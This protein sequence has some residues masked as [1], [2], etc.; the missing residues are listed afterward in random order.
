[1]SY[2]IPETLLQWPW[3]RQQNVHDAEVGPESTLWIQ[4]FNA[5][6]AKSQRAFDLCDFNE[7]RSSC[8]M[9]HLFF[10]IDELSD[11]ETGPV[12]REQAASIMDAFRN[13]YAQRPAG[14]SIL[15]EISRQ[16]WGRTLERAKPSALT[17][18]RFIATFDAYTA[19]VATQ[20]NDR[21]ADFVRDIESYLAVRRNTIGTYPSFV[22]LELGM[23]LPEDVLEHSIIRDMQR[24]ISELIAVSNDLYSY[25]IEQARGDSG[26]N[27]LTVAMHDLGT[28]LDGAIKW[29]GEYCD[30]LERKF[31]DA[32]NHL[33]SW[34]R[35]IDEQVTHYVSGFGN[36]ARANEVWSFE[37]PRYFGK[38]GRAVQKNRM[39]IL[40]PKRF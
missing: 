21:D 6:D 36:W 3:S 25:N 28:G 12:V 30:I 1:M 9:M 39:V 37:T 19:A 15:G 31:K 17:Q 27:V 40:L 13:P 16:F 20:A 22:F 29:T 14:E 7:L 23:D 8:D 33:P 38:E 4:S 24:Y 18:Q 5:L 10:M 35:G 2:L 32:A 34:G 11:Q 26:H